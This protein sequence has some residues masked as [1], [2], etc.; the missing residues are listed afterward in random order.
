MKVSTLNAI[1]KIISRISN[2]SSL[3][4]LYRSV[5]LG[6]ETIRACSEFGNI[7][8]IIHTGLSHQCL[9]DANALHSVTST[10]SS[11][12]EIE[13]N[14]LPSKIE[15]KS[16]AA[17]GHLSYVQTDYSIPKIKHENFP[18]IPPADLGNALV[19]ASSSCQ[20][21]AVSFGL[22]GI[23][24]EPDK[25]KLNIAS[26]NTISLASSSVEL[27]TYPAQK[28]TLRPPVPSIISSLMA[29]SPNCAMDV[30]SEGIFM[31]G[32]GLMAHLPLGVN[33]D[34]NVKEIADKYV[35]GKEIAKINSA[36]VKKFIK[37]AQG[38][39]DKKATFNIALKIEE[40]RLILNHLGISSSVEEWMLAEDL[41][42]TIK[43]ES[44]SFPGDMLIVPLESVSEIVLDFMPQ[45][46]LVFRGSNPEFLYVVSG[47]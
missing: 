3:T 22:Y 32:D 37:R 23:V 39:T 16:D 2:P 34:H 45:Q 7:E 12:S 20:A 4:S 14:K 10:L 6:P 42:T 30:T 24:M 15:W 38:L 41:S 29:A 5:E 35:G 21:A 43:Y 46:Q 8:L 25:N 9:I 47:N 19:L 27:G 17:S 26:T 33:L 40:G 13:I 44:R 1:L 36:A 18:W 11:N 31:L 28:V